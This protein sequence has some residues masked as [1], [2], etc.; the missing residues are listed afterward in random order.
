MPLA[1]AN[2]KVCAPLLLGLSGAAAT[3]ENNI[4]ARAAASRNFLLEPV[5]PAAR[6]LLGGGGPRRTTSLFQLGIG[7]DRLAII[8]LR[9][10]AHQPGGE[11][12]IGALHLVL[13]GLQHLADARI[14]A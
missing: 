1:S 14:G 8:G 3:P 6:L 13:V 2:W 9:R 7:V 5:K 12:R 4:S 10:R 11:A